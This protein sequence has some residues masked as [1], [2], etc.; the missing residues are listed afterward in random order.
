LRLTAFWAV[1]LVGLLSA[2]WLP[3]AS[4]AM[5]ADATDAEAITSDDNTHLSTD[6][7]QTLLRE[8]Y[9]KGSFQGRD[10]V[11]FF[12]A[13]GTT[14]YAEHSSRPSVGRWKTESSQYCSQWPPASNWDCY[15]IASDGRAVTF[16]PVGGGPEWVGRIVGA[17][18]GHKPLDGT[19]PL[20]GVSRVQSLKLGQ[21]TF[22]TTVPEGYTLELLTHQ[23]QQPR[24]LHFFGERLLIGSRAGVVYALDPPYTQPQEVIRLDDYPHSLVVHDEHLYIARTSRIDKVPYTLATESI[25]ERELIPVVAL[26]G[27]RGHNTRTLKIGP[28]SQ[29]YVSLGISG[30]CSDEYLDPAYPDRLQRGGLAIVDETTEPASL[31]AFASGLRNPVGFDWHPR[32]RTLFATNNGPDHLGYES[33]A[34]YFAEVLSGSFFGMPWFQYTDGELQR[35]QCIESKPPLAAAQVTLPA[36]LLAPR[37][38][39]MDMVFLDDVTGHEDYSNDAIVALHGSWA[40][41]NGSGNGDPATRRHPKLVHIKFVTGRPTRVS[42]FVTGFQL[43]DGARWARPMGL[44][45]DADGHIYFSSDDGIQGLYRL[46]RDAD[47]G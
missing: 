33:P 28:D 32:T 40:T 26:P 24:V 8:R 15:H 22:E 35:D 14:T 11:S 44:A 4:V 6:E 7:I 46:R 34:E 9:V 1:I 37:S 12:A 39:P 16:L 47:A 18:D 2:L 43:P 29:L 27:G 30:N 5:A 19:K 13:D 25:A 17:S 20:P 36:A 23:M 41:A 45:V 21:Y 38:A 31:R 42:D 10:W 3:V